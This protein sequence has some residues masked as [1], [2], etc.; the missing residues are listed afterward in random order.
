MS[1]ILR[2]TPIPVS[3][4]R[5]DRWRPAS[6]QAPLHLLQR[7]HWNRHDR[8]FYQKKGTLRC[9]A[10]RVAI[11]AI[12][13]PSPERCDALAVPF[14]DASFLCCEQR[15]QFDKDCDL[16]GNVQRV[17]CGLPRGQE[18]QNFENGRLLR[19]CNQI[20]LPI[21]CGQ[22]AD[23]LSKLVPK[24]VSLITCSRCLGWMLDNSACRMSVQPQ[25][26]QRGGS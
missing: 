13:K 11:D 14:H 1:A 23:R 15:G 22:R 24:R 17:C 16:F 3:I 20:R 26:G 18:C 10:G 2:W 9:G 21:G 7:F 5:W 8:F 12:L 6:L 4:H 25:I 19:L